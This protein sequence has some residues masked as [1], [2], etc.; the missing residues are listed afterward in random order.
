MEQLNKNGGRFTEIL[1][2][3]YTCEIICAIQYLHRNSIIYRDLKLENVL[4]TRDG[5][6]KLTDFGMSKLLSDQGTT[7]FCGTAECMAPEIAKIYFAK[8]PQDLTTYNYMVD[9]FSLGV[10]IF[11]MITGFSPFNRDDSEREDILKSIISDCPQCPNSTSPDAQKCIYGLL[12]KDFKKR[13]G[14]DESPYGRLRDQSFFT[15]VEWDRIELGAIEPPLKP[16][17]ITLSNNSS[18]IKLEDDG[19]DDK[20]DYLKDIFDDF[21]F[22]SEYFK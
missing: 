8:K 9:Y 22:I 13:L 2:R 16:H 3:F 5:H 7:T 11:H 1:T 4:L 18:E 21:N 10:M 20:F 19:E 12:E 6:V 15:N 17:Y 14:S